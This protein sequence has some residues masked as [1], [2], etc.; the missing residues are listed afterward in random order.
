MSA[1]PRLLD[2]PSSTGLELWV[3]VGVAAVGVGA[4]VA[5]GVTGGV[6]LGVADGVTDGVALGVA[7]E[8]CGAAELGGVDGI[9]GKAIGSSDRS[10]GVATDTGNPTSGGWPGSHVNAR[11]Q[12][13]APNASP[14]TGISQRRRRRAGRGRATRSRLCFPRVRRPPGSALGARG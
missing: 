13:S 4:G 1:T 11:T 5:D 2:G 14:P 3:C 9:S 10:G 12:S 7:E 8:L 6:A